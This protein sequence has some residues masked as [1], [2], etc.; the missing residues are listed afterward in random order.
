MNVGQN[1]VYP[2]TFSFVDSTTC[3]NLSNADTAAAFVGVDTVNYTYLWDDGETTAYATALPHGE[4]HVTL[5]DTLGCPETDS[6]A[7]GAPPQYTLST[8]V[9]DSISCFGNS[10]GSAS[11]SITSTDYPPYTYNWSNQQT[12]DTTANLAAGH[13]LCDRL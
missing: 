10:D 12:G 7:I 5:K 3:F 6:V 11:V 8:T 9:V 4:R 1:A 13:L 2:I